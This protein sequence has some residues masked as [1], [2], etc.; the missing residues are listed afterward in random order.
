MSNGATFIPPNPQDNYQRELILALKSVFDK[1]NE[2]L[3]YVSRLPAKTVTAEYDIQDNDS[4]IL[5]NGN[6]DVNLP[7]A[8]PSLNRS[9][10]IKNIGSSAVTVV[11]QSGENIDGNNDYELTSQYDTIQIVSDGT[12]WHIVSTK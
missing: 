6:F 9:L 2:N 4:I 1:I 3:S 11:A 7:L 8:K 5:A 10:T 12:D